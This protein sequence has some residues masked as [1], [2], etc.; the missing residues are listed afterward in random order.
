MEAEEAIKNAQD[1]INW[2]LEGMAPESEERLRR[3]IAM[4]EFF[5]ETVINI[6]EK[7]VLLEVSGNMYADHTTKEVIA[8]LYD[9]IG[10]GRT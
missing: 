1:L 8:M 2:C 10:K 9:L 6:Q 3:D 7:I 4:L 5:I